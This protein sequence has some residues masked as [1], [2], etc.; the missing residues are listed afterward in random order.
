MFDKEYNK[1]TTDGWDWDW[2]KYGGLVILKRTEKEFWR[3]TP[4]EWDAL[5]RVHID[6]NSPKKKEKPIVPID[7]VL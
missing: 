2:F 5:M 7:Y 1:R 3:M 6:V 4:R